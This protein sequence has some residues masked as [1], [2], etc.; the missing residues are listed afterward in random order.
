MG[1]DHGRIRKHLLAKAEEVFRDLVKL[2]DRRHKHLEAAGLGDINAFST[3]VC[4]LAK[5]LHG[6]FPDVIVSMCIA[7]AFLGR[8]ASTS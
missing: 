6:S 4:Q 5:D 3:L 8:N 1:M 7:I 2:H